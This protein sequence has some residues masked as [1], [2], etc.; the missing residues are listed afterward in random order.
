MNP[1]LEVTAAAQGGVFSRR[2]ALAA[3]Y[4]QAQIRERLTDGRWRRLRRGQY[5]AASKF[6]H[7][8]SWR[9]RTAEHLELVH[10]A[11]N[12]MSPG[13]V[14]VSHQSALALH[15]VPVWDASMDEVHVTRVDRAG[16]RSLAGVRHHNGLLAADDLCEVEGLLVTTPARAAFEFACTTGFESAVVSF[17]AVLAAGAMTPADG[18]R[19]LAAT[20]FWPGSPTARAAR[21]FATGLSESVGESRLR[22]LMANHGLPPPALQ[23]ELAD[24]TGTF[25]RVDFYFP[26]N[27]TVVEFD[28]LVK[29][30]AGGAEVLAREK[31][32]EDRL[33][34]LGLQVVRITWSDLSDP[35]VVVGRI[36]QAF[37]RARKTA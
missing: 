23:V 36:R 35:A 6:G 2:Q 24:P 14:A 12:S 30:A 16:G 34:A 9:R 32:R 8:P 20:A 33:R 11:V 27:R 25:A 3:G 17:D 22:V 37:D 4:T 31:V 10:A 1:E 21:R 15:R 29:Y 28:G 5:A 19:L 13:M 26:E 7:L 18:D